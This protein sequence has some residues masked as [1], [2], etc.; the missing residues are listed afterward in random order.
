MG[1]VL[2]FDGLAVFRDAGRSGAF[3]ACVFRTVLTFLTLFLRAPLPARIFLRRASFLRADLLRPVLLRAV[4]LRTVLLRTVLALP[5]AFLLVA[6]AAS[7]ALPA[8]RPWTTHYPLKRVKEK[9]K[10]TAGRIIHDV[11]SAGNRQQY[12][13]RSRE[14]CLAGDQFVDGS[15]GNGHS[16]VAD[17]QCFEIEKWFV[18]VA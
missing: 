5:F 16:R 14:L 8:F 6:I 15:A 11:S 9:D 7:L 10:K 12:P 13:P 18:N 1:L 2:G 3:L 4:L 17:P